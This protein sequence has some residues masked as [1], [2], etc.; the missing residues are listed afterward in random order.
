MRRKRTGTSRRAAT[1]VASI[2][3]PAEL[4]TIRVRLNRLPEPP[5]LARLGKMDYLGGLAVFLLVF[6]STFPVV[7]PFLL[8]QQPLPAC[9]SP[10]PSPSQCCSLPGGRTGAAPAAGPGWRNCHG[11]RRPRPRRHDHG[12]GRMS[13]GGQDEN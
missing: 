7:I 11:R 5:K 10:T 9:A 4:E 6:L 8:M 1:A 3:E 13:R 2:L 12:A